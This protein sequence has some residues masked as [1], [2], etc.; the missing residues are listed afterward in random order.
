EMVLQA[1]DLVAGYPGRIVATVAGLR[2]GRGARVAVVGP[3]GAG[4]TTLVRTLIG[5]IP[6]LDGYVS[7]APTARVG[8]LAQ[9]QHDLG[10]GSVL[11]ALRAATGMPEQA[12][13]DLLA[14]FLFRGEDVFKDV[15]VLSGGERS[16]LALARLGARE[17]NLL[18][19]D[20]P[21]NHLDVAARE[22]LEAVLLDYDGAILF[23]SHDR[24][25]IDKLATEVWLVEGG[26]LERH[27]GNWSSLQ[28]L[29]AAEAAA[30]NRRREKSVL[31]WEGRRQDEGP[32]RHPQA[33]PAMALRATTVRRRPSRGS[34]RDVAA[35]EARIK[36]MEER[37]K[38]LEQRLAD[39]A[40]SG[41]YMETRRVGEEHASLEEALRALYDE[42]AAKSE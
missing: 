9:A 16:R 7:S 31:A 37:I 6:A 4:K 42:W 12:A 18:V 13:R 3:N 2:L 40:S 22:A 15:A 28:S 14:R 27:Q 30:A 24:Y 29:R 39:V 25:L 34:A 33:R 23:V 19:L 36:E 21:T 17:A 26:T 35:L 1:T 8:Y 41:N 11:D 20:E 10:S 5:R 32:G 38:A